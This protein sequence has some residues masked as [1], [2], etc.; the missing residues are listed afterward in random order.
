MLIQP[1]D[2][3]RHQDRHLVCRWRRVHNRSCARVQNVVL[4]TPVFARRGSPPSDALD[5]ALVNF[6]DQ[7][8]DER[9]AGAE[10][11]GDELERGPVVEEFLDVVR[12]RPGHR[13]AGEESLALLQGELCF[14]DVSRMVR[15]EDER[16][17]THVPDPVLGERRCLEKP[18]RPLDPREIRLD[19]AGDRE[20]RPESHRGTA[21]RTSIL[22]VTAAEIMAVRNSLRRSMPS[23]TLAMRASILTVSR[24][25][26]AVMA[27]CSL[28]A[29][30]GMR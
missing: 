15:L 3:L 10:P 14:F 18:S 23:L 19:R 11:G 21:S 4:D 30:N 12:V 5:E 7:S 2:Q 25:R 28:V 17:L 27:R 20:A 16:P 22:P 1:I 26:R 9:S 8:L 6:P 13:L 29:G 24:S